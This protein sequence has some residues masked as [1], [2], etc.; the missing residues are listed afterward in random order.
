MPS[1]ARF[2]VKQL[3]TGLASKNLF[4]TAFRTIAVIM[5]HCDWF[6]LDENQ[7][8]FLFSLIEEKTH[9]TAS[10]AIAFA[11]L[12]A[13]LK[14]KVMLPVV[15]DL[16][17]RVSHLMVQSSS[18]PVRNLCGE[19]MLQ[20][21]LDYPLGE[22]RLG[23]HLTFLIN[24]LKYEYPS[25][26]LSVLSF[27]ELLCSKFPT[28]LLDVHSNVIFMHL[29]MRLSKDDNVECRQRISD[30][31]TALYESVSASKKKSMVALVSKWLPS[32]RNLSDKSK[33][34]ASESLPS[35]FSTSSFEFDPLTENLP[36]TVLLR[37]TVAVQVVGILASSAEGGFHQHCK[38]LMAG[39]LTCF[40]Q[41]VEWQLFNTKT[42]ESTSNEDFSSDPAAMQ[43][44]L[45]YQVL[46]A[47]ER[48]EEAVGKQVRPWLDSPPLWKKIVR[49]LLHPHAWCRATACRLAVRYLGWLELPRF[50]DADYPKQT[51]LGDQ[52]GLFEFGSQLCF[53]L[54]AMTLSKGEASSILQGLSFVS[55]AM[56]VSPH[57]KGH[58]DSSLKSVQINQD[59]SDG[60]SGSELEA[61]PQGPSS[62]DTTDWNRG[63]NWLMTRLSYL[64]RFTAPGARVQAN[65]SAASERELQTMKF[66]HVLV[67]ECVFKWISFLCCELP[68]ESMAPY[69]TQALSALIRVTDAK[70]QSP[71]LSSLAQ[72]TMEG[73]QDLVGQEL[74]LTAYSK[75]QSGLR[76]TREARRQKRKQLAVKLP[77][78]VWHSF[79]N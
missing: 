67:L 75:V 51:F 34:S 46:T 55:L 2:V 40:H 57:Y 17:K 47:L 41:Q 32:S 68:A 62:T 73:L 72:K 29:V 76:D 77:H 56:H 24:N 70:E 74:F 31:I 37:Q 15:Y 14:R 6:A 52:E 28:E 9:E 42:E 43:W 61:G 26:R 8:K 4:V 59:D 53:Q 65:G 69:L 20:F 58:P 5:R 60:S 44:N 16:M 36:K 66:S 30:V 64:T 71:Q 23:Q 22:K 25:G 13:L 38:S 18:S 21:L 35:S 39:V 12:K 79:K 48:V 27:L 45:L 11:L 54:D 63:L 7:T 33:S 19:C 1:L 50:V 78:V 3:K 10:H 49:C